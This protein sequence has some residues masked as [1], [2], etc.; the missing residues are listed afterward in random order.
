MRRFWIVVALALALM[1]TV[2]NVM[3]SNYF[4]IDRDGDGYG[5]GSPLGPDADDNDPLVNTTA[6]AMDRYGSLDGYLNSQGYQPNRVI[7]LSPGFDWNQYRLQV[8]PGDAYVLR[9]G[10]YENTKINFSNF[11]GDP[12]NPVIVT[13]Y[14]GEKVIFDTDYDGFSIRGS[15]DIVIDGFT[16]TNTRN[17]RSYNG[18]YI[19]SDQVLSNYQNV[20][21]ITIRNIEASNKGRGIKA[22]YDMHDVLIENV[23]TY[24]NASHGVYLGATENPNS[25][26]TYRDNIS[27]ANGRHGIQHNGPIGNLVI[28]DNIIHSNKYGG[29]SLL[30]GVHDSVVRDNLVFSNS[31]QGLVLF[32]YDEQYYDDREPMVNNLI[33]NNLFWVGY[34]S[35]SGGTGARDHSAIEMTDGTAAN[36]ANILGNTIRGNILVS[37]MGGILRASDLVFATDNEFSGNVM[38]RE[39]GG[40]KVV[41]LFGEVMTLDEWMALNPDVADNIWMSLEFADVDISYW[42]DVS[43]FDFTLPP[44]ADGNFDG[45]VDFSDFMILTTAWGNR[46]PVGA[47]GGDFDGSGEVGFEDFLMMAQTWG[48][49]TEFAVPEPSAMLLLGVGSVAWLSRR[50]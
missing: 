14:P 30:L 13:S 20:E 25:N 34:Y 7:E 12:D 44:T 11:R 3:A 36:V 5:V 15:T 27:Y 18:V 40:K 16:V 24:N 38:F 48:Q 33:E 41:D 42:S 17:L 2:S 9:G 19:Y 4:F 49:T 50:R 26:I 47:L 43:L 46:T 28:E 29:I 32:Q 1:G 8:Q 10:T 31:R 23:V 22:M 37:Q 21:R 6:S 45:V 39:W 35:S